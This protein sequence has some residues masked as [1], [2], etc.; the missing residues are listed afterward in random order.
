MKYNVMIFDDGFAADALKIL[1]QGQYYGIGICCT[2][3][4]VPEA[5]LVL[6]EVQPQ[7]VILNL[8]FPGVFEFI[9]S[10]EFALQKRV[11]IF[12]ID[13]D[14]KKLTN[15]L[16]NGVDFL[17]KPFSAVAVAL[18]KAVQHYELLQTDP[19]AAGI[20]HQSLLNLH[21]Q[22]E[23]NRPAEQIT[24]PVRFGYQIVNLSDV[25]YLQADE[26]YTILYLTD[27]R[28]VVSNLAIDGFRRILP[29]AYF[30]QINTF[31]I[32]NLNFL[33]MRSGPV[34]NILLMSDGTVRTVSK[35]RLTAF[36]NRL[37]RQKGHNDLS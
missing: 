23:K 35:S 13:D 26:N 29:E 3:K 4:A 21:A 1:L 34:G 33:K 15:L 12:T 6:K 25:I 9:F 28:V 18:L 19:E 2:V 20:Y 14:C 10:T 36:D 22:V 31:T 7:I 16:A 27:A 30:F 5:K 24:V 8:A 11:I 32:I 37:A 17:T